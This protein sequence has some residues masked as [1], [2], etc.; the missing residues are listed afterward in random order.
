MIIP[1]NEHLRISANTLNW[2]IEARVTNKKTGKLDGWDGDKFYSLNKAGG[3]RNALNCCATKHLLG[4]P[5]PHPVDLEVLTKVVERLEMVEQRIL[6][7]YAT[8]RKLRELA[9]LNITAEA[10]GFRF[11]LDDPY[12]VQ[13]QIPNGPGK[14]KSKNYFNSLGL[15]LVSTLHRLVRGSNAEGRHEV[16]RAIH[17]TEMALRTVLNQLPASYFSAEAEPPADVAATTPPKTGVTRAHSDPSA[18]AAHEGEPAIAASTYP[19]AL[20]AL[21]PIPAPARPG[22]FFA[23][24]RGFRVW[25]S[26]AGL[27]HSQHARLDQRAA[28]ARLGGGNDRIAGAGHQAGDQLA[29][30]R[31]G[32]DGL[33]LEDGGRGRIDAGRIGRGEGGRLDRLAR[34]EPGGIVPADVFGLA[35]V[36]VVE[37]HHDGFLAVRTHRRGRAAST[38]RRG[39]AIRM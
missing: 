33:A 31:A 15:A 14:W 1:I 18:S 13:R 11:V 25:G 3:L 36:L 30:D 23:R 6:D 34:F 4:H 38:G 19:Q 20:A 24:F 16:M 2:I 29:H 26:S 32:D 5:L 17:E 28:A 22:L 9:E 21:N 27:A 39:R 35:G 37:V 10:G 12:C 8:P 7:E